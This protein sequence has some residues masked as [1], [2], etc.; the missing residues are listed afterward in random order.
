VPRSV[1][2]KIKAQ[3]QN[4]E[5]YGAIRTSS[6]PCYNACIPCEMREILDKGRDSF[7]DTRLAETNGMV[8]QIHSG[9]TTPL[10]SKRGIVTAVRDVIEEKRVEEL[11]LEGEE[12]SLSLLTNSPN[13]ILVVNPDTSIRYVN[14]A[15]ER[16]TGYSSSEVVGGKP[17]YPWWSKE[18]IER[19]T[20]RLKDHMVGGARYYE[21]RWQR[22]NGEYFWVEINAATIMRGESLK[23]YLSIW[24]DITERKRMEEQLETSLSM[25]SATL[26]STADGILVVNKDGKIANYNQRYVEMFHIPEP[27]M[28][29]QDDRK[30]VE[31]IQKQ[32]KDPEAYY[33]RTRELF[34]HPELERLDLLEFKDGSVFERYS[35]PQQTG[36]E[37]IGRVI[38]F[39]D[40]TERKRAEEKLKSYSKNLEGLVDAK[41]K[42][43]GQSEERYRRLVENSPDMIF[44]HS[45]GKIVYMNPAGA[46][47]LGAAN[48]EKLIGK[49]ILDIVHPDY[50]E[51]VK[52]RIVRALEER[53]EA[54]LTEQKY[55]REDG[56][57]IDVEVVAIPSTY[58]GRPAVQGVARDIT[59]RK[60]ME[61]ALLDSE[62]LAAIGETA[63]M[64]GHDLRNP[65]QVLFNMVY[66]TI[67]VINNM[68]SYCRVI[69]EKQGLDNISGRIK[70]Q[71]EYMNKI[72]SDLQDYAR[73]VKLELVETQILE[74]INHA[75]STITIPENIRVYKI[76]GEDSPELV[77]DP[78]FMQRVFINLITN[79][80][81]AMPGGGE[82]TIRSSNTQDAVFIS[83][84]DTGTGI[85]EDTMNKLFNPLF[86]TKAKGQ[87]L[88]LAVCKRMVEA[89]GGSIIVESE[90]G[91]GTTFT[92]KMPIKRR[93]CQ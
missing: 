75:L 9:H 80:L 67:E 49:P 7:K 88:G 59:E 44:A 16:I 23:Y 85:P 61:K 10:D 24:V 11:S 81:Q 31:F 52:K 27:V 48:P 51:A 58:R 54:R 47:L 36:E 41:I 50:Q 25:L 65:L 21:E 74:I 19:V 92:I 18:S 28:K 1:A 46:T 69:M 56:K 77:V 82:L 89:H 86:T 68:P 29:S 13:P 62:R 8:S 4:T 30:L 79:A 72:V 45:E 26:E 12:F 55:L 87:G 73:P 6:S 64:V 53:R 39:R 57:T 70:E 83:F 5:S 32:V 35:R 66:L 90:A 22:K 76:I 33:K 15:L 37:V 63:A 3:T 34:T 38:S 71:V 84:Q 40:V 93:V 2:V 43:L 78:L 42:E 17:P 91:S 60:K 20:K 14:P